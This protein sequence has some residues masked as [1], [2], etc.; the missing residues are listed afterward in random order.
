MS[1][2]S[3]V[4]KYDDEYLMTGKRG[5]YVVECNYLTD[6]EKKISEE[7]LLNSG[8]IWSLQPP[9][10]GTNK[11]SPGYSDSFNNTPSWS[12]S[13]YSTR[14]FS[15]IVSYNSGMSADH[16][17]NWS[18]HSNNNCGGCKSLGQQNGFI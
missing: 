14:S 1:R 2:D 11:Y 4:G 18:S 12:G 16:N 17:N 13:I 3:C 9:N 6:F 10:V 8:D 5:N 15:T 7:G